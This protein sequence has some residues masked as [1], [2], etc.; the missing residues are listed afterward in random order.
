MHLRMA[1]LGNEFLD[2]GTGCRRNVLTVEIPKLHKSSPSIDWFSD[3]SR[4]DPPSPPPGP[5]PSPSMSVEI[6]ENRQ[7][8]WYGYLTFQVTFHS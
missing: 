7:R 2:V 1:N 5:P 4:G 8:A 3:M 6:T